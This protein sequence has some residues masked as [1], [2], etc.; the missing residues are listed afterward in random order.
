MHAI[1][2]QVHLKSGVRSEHCAWTAIGLIHLLA[3]GECT[4]PAQLGALAYLVQ[5]P[6]ARPLVFLCIHL[7]VILRIATEAVVGKKGTVTA[8][9]DVQFRIG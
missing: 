4:S 2:S 7:N 8:V 1:I 3:E 6:L 9:Q 5:A